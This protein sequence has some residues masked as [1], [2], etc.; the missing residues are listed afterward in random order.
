MM[1]NNAKPFYGDARKFGS[2]VLGEARE[3]WQMTTHR[4]ARKEIQ[5][6]D[7]NEQRRLFQS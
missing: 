7:G 4:G 3:F 2:R 6:D 5:E 1:K